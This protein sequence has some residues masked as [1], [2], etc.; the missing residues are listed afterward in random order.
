MRVSIQL[1]TAAGRRWGRSY[2]VDPA[3]SQLHVPVRDLRPVDG[4]VAGT[5]DPSDATSLLI[6]IDLTNASPGRS[7]T[8]RVLSSALE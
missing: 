4:G 8:L 1:R 6:V 2:Y 7:G 3:G 5:F